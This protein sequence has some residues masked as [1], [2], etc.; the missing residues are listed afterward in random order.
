ML[1]KPSRVIKEERTKV[2]EEKKKEKVLARSAQGGN[3][4]TQEN[5]QNQNVKAGQSNN[6][7]QQNQGKRK[8]N[9]QQNR[10]QQ[11][12][13]NANVNPSIPQ[14]SICG[15]KHSGQCRFGTTGCYLCGREGHYAKN[16]PN[17]RQGQSGVPQ[18]RQPAP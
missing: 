8:G 11:L 2:W 1:F 10:N 18:L 14:C 5:K 12:K 13:P 17:N 6:Q 16:Y 3:E 4:S 7:G 15:K 9:F